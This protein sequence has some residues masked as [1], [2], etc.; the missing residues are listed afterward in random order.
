[1]NYLREINAF[2]YWLETNPLDAITQNLWFHLMGIANRCNWPEWFTVANITLQAK[3]GG[4]DKKT[5]IRHRNILVQK[6]RIEYV[7]QGKREAG[8]YRMISIVED[9]SGNN[10]PNEQPNTPPKPPPKRPPKTPPLNKHKHKTK[11]EE[12]NNALE[13][14]IGDFKDFRK[15]IK[16]PMTDRA[17]SL[18]RGELEKL[19]PSDDEKKIAILNQSIM[20]GWKG[21]FAL[22][23]G[24]KSNQKLSKAA[25][26]I[27][28]YMG[29]DPD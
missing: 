29:G 4:V 24:G 3:I 14:A 12:E 9:I 22:K 6:G 19:A 26:S 25:A 20:N 16:A 5:L 11:P 10:P 7:N 1:M 21:V 8:K 2:I 15:K 17:E 28:S 13:I 27:L 23:D 18:L